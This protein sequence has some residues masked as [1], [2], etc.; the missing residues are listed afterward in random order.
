MMGVYPA[1]SVVQL[2][3]DRYALVVG[4]NSTRPLKPRVLVHDPSAAR[5]GAAPQPRDSTR[6]GHPA[7]PEAAAAAGDALALPGAAAARGLLL[8]AALRCDGLRRGDRCVS[9]ERGARAVRGRR[10]GRGGLPAGWRCCM[11]W[12]TRPG[13]SMRATSRWR[14]IAPRWRCWRAAADLLGQRRRELIGTPEDLCFWDEVPAGRTGQLHP[15][16]DG[17][18]RRRQRLL[19]VTRSISPLSRRAAGPTHYV[20]A[21]HD[22]SA[23]A[24]RRGRARNAAGRAAGHARIHR[25]R[26]P[27]DRPGRPRPRLQPALRRAL[28]PAEGPADRARRRRGARLDAAQRRRRRGYSAGWPRS[29]DATLLQRQRRFSCTRAACSS[30]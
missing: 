10:R 21:L 2:T 11:R 24:A 18:D 28:G 13:S 23:T 8:R 22:R 20:V 26:H 1:G 29:Q 15:T 9:V 14:P 3:D 7:Q 6:P 30:A 19:P 27:G 12:A 16:R 25:R 4:V 17:D 5:R